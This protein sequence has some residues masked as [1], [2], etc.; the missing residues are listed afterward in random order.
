MKSV[1]KSEVFTE[2]I[3]TKKLA[4][5]LR[6]RELSEKNVVLDYTSV[7]SNTKEILLDGIKINIRKERIDPPFIV[8]VE[9]DFPFLKIHFEIKGSSKYSPKNDKSVAVNI[10]GGHYNFFYLPKVKGVLRYDTSIRN[11][12]EIVFT[13]AYLKRVFGDSLKKI[14]AGFGDALEKDI[15][16]LMW[17]QSRPIPSQLYSIIQEIINCKFKEGIKK[18]YLESKI[19][20]ILTIFFDCLKEK[21]ESPIS[22]KKI[23]KEDYSKIIIAE[24]ILRKNLKDPP[25]ISELS[26]ITGINQFKLKQNFKLVFEKP[27]FSYLTQLRMENAKRLITEKEYTIAEASYEVGYKNP[28]HF[29][30]AF[31]RKYNYLP[32][33]LKTY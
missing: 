2:K 20:E 13:K 1:F 3:I 15:P 14:S 32:S 16:F 12:L 7:K 6:T 18:A 31:K 21:R 17:E 11:T 24:D 28:Q 23:S 19:T 5:G 25:T 22:G 27:I 30:A 9:H 33:A 10:P 4:P 8:E 29:T 26:I